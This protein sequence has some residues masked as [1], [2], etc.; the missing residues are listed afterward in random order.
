MHQ[1]FPFLKKLFKNRYSIISLNLAHVFPHASIVSDLSKEE[2]TEVISNASLKGMS[3]IKIE[4][5]GDKLI[6][7]ANESFAC[8]PKNHFLVK[9]VR[10][11]AKSLLHLQEEKNIT[12]K[13]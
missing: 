9:K 3:A 11:V 12:V 5:Y 2:I 10:F 7:F 8:V 13:K 6:Q 1:T 4:N